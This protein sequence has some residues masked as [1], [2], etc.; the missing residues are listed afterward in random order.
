MFDQFSDG[1]CP[2]CLLENRRIP[3][4]LNDDDFW[5]CPTCRLQASTSGMGM[6]AIQRKR[7]KGNLREEKATPWVRGLVLTKAHAEDP[8]RPDASGFDDEL[9]LRKFLQ[10]DVR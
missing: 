10:E 3:M 7:G 8:Y 6:F 2:Q 1:D 5:E 9:S 4:V